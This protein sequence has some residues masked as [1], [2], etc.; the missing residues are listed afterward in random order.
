MLEMRTQCHAI[1]YL[2]NTRAQI[3]CSASELGDAEALR[4]LASKIAG[5]TV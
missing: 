3:C 2:E 1:G 4:S 5:V